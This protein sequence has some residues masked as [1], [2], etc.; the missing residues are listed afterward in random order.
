MSYKIGAVQRKFLLLLFHNFSMG[1]YFPPRRRAEILSRLDREWEAV[2]AE[3]LRRAIA[4]LYRNRLVSMK[5]LPDGSIE[6]ILSDRGKK[7]ALAYQLDEMKIEKAGAWDG[8]WRF[9]LFDIPRHKR[10]AFA[11]LSAAI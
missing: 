7:R 11:I 5:D 6:I 4:Q 8:K 9:I 10:K 3:T 2:K 1:I